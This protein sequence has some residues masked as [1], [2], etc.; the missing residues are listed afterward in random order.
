L[1]F[2]CFITTV[3]MASLTL[4]PLSYERAFAQGSTSTDN[5]QNSSFEPTVSKPTW[6]DTDNNG[7]ADTLD[8]E[9]SERITNGTANSFVSVTVLLKVASTVQDADDFV[10][11][12]GY[13]TTSAWTEA[14]YGFGGM[15]TYAGIATFA[16][17]CPDVLLVEKEAVGK[18]AIAY[19]AQ[20]VGA[21]TYIWNTVGLRGDPNTAIATLDTGVDASHVDFQPGYGNLNFSKKI[22]G[23]IDEIGFTNAPTD[24]NGH[25]SH[26]AGLATGDGFF[27]VDAS[28][29][30]ITT[31]G[32][33]LGPVP[34]SGT[35]AVAGVPVNKPGTIT[36][37]VK[38]G[39]TGTGS[40]LTGI[41]LAYGDKTLTTR[42]Q[43]A[44]V[45]TPS[46]NQFYSLNYTVTSTPT[47]AFDMYHI[48]LTVAQGSSTSDLYVTFTLSWPYTPPSDGFQAWTGI[49]PQSKLVGIKVMNSLGS[50]TANELI[51]GINWLIN[52]RQA[53]HVTVASMSL[54][55]A[56]EQTSV[57]AAVLNLVNSGVAVVVAAGN[58]GSGGNRVYTCGSVDEVTTVAAMNQFDAVTDFSSQGGTS[59]YRGATAKPDIMCPGG[60]LDGLPIFSADSNYNDAEG[61][62]VDVQPNDSAPLQG[63]SMATPIISGCEQ[64]LIQALGGFAKWNYTS[65]TSRSLAL[66]PKMLLLMTAT[67]TYPN[68]RERNT[69]VGSPTLDRGGKDVHEGYGRVNLDAA[70]DA[71]LQSYVVGSVVTDTLG[72][73]PT[74]A[75]TSVLGQH[76]A[77]ARNVQ[78]TSGNTYNFSLAVPAGGDYDLYL[79]N[80]T[81]TA[82]GEPSTV[83]RSTNATTGRTEQVYV[84][85]PYTGTY[86][87]V[88]K[89][90]TETTGGG[91]FTLAS[92]GPNIVTVTLNT[93][94][95]QSAVN[96]VHYTQSGAS[97]D[98]SIVAGALSVTVDPSTTVMIDNPINVSATQRYVTS[99]PTSFTVEASAVYT[100]NY[101]TQFYIAVNSVH[102]T[103][104]AS[105]W[106]D[107][108]SNLTFSVS[109]PTEVV[110]GD[111]QWVCGGVSVDDG[112]ALA[113]LTSYTFNVVM[114]A[115]TLVF[116][117][118][119]QFYLTV[120][121]AY[122]SQSGEGWYN[123]GALAEASLMTGVVSVD[124]GIQ[125]VFRGWGGDASGAALTSD[126]IT[127]SGPKTATASW[128]TQ[129]YVNASANFGSVNPGSGWHDANS[130]FTMTASAPS[131]AFGERFVWGNWSGVG[132][133]SYNGA[134]IQPTFT[135]TGP[136]TETATWVHQFML[137]VTS[138]F[139]SPMPM[140]GW[141]DAGAPINVSVPS[142]VAG[143][144]V[145]QYVCLGWQGTGSV[146]RSGTANSADFALTQPSSIT[147]NWETRYLLVPLA[148]IVGVPVILVIVA[149]GVVL[150]RRKGVKISKGTPEAGLAPSQSSV[151]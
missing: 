132:S 80:S 140:T 71:V 150:R 60:S 16:Q 98:G 62:F 28:G 143:S 82:Y 46:Q 61:H 89:R 13:L 44:S 26:V 110:Q 70:V 111:H 86:Y 53:Y 51:N 34:A 57:D 81:G 27:S 40:T 138:A 41:A 135:I 113:G 23:W 79:Y 77:W 94:G 32:A 49:A 144:I 122:D 55:F 127:M 117:W 68:L 15:T 137:T 4:M 67:E 106:A 5:Q 29:N 87:V 63:T 119:E 99:D 14:V 6:V 30:A 142:P 93:P 35:Y 18:A 120:N 109:S 129:Y 11:S 45:S 126:A 33:D 20:Q 112:P 139:G 24:D 54:G 121:S 105:Q 8:Q 133:S 7:I 69:S 1:L 9:I 145:T 115:H 78:L 12:G 10:T 22:I 102:D 58:D 103:P 128:K 59:R 72:M 52:N 146:P 2:A 92:S 118:K 91:T 100:V 19:A 148:V 83:A 21:R 17:K 50:G 73:P 74:V 124:P 96:V 76:L 123:S 136:F 116:N 38:W 75:D 95:L 39:H 149:V 47:S 43:V 131:A 151:P 65:P 130:V 37:N 108:G 104:P 101:K 90:A 85:A 3:L 141:F 48:G 66:Q 64:I 31:W 84:K 25:G 42:T 97:K 56:T 134:D 147:W 88:V 114:S 107:Q 36:L 125:Y